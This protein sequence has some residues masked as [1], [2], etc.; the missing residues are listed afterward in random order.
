MR[1]LMLAM[2]VLSAAAV[3]FACVAPADVQDDFEGR[4]YEAVS[5]LDSNDCAARCDTFAEQASQ[6]VAAPAFQSS[7]CELAALVA[8]DPA[9]ARPAPSCLCME[10]D[11]QD[12]SL[13]VSATGPDRCLVYGRD[14]SCLYEADAFLGCDLNAPETSCEATCNEVQRRLEVDAIRKPSARVRTAACSE[15][16][17]HCV[18][19]ISGSCYVDD[20]LDPYD[21]S[22]SDNEIIT[23]FESHLTAT[24]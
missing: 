14:R 21:C 11:S 15:T 23:T 4:A 20:W 12:S 3:A 8:G 22:R 13:L 9:D 18:L 1:R 6:A 10:G 19:D 17:C 7:R 24:K 16:G 5:C 2:L